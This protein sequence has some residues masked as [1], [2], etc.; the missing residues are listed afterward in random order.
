MK[1]NDPP[2]RYV[3]EGRL[4]LRKHRGG[5]G[6][7]LAVGADHISE[8]RG[9]PFIAKIVRRNGCQKAFDVDDMERRFGQGF[10][11]LIG[12]KMIVLG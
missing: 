4:S 11:V 9:T 1:L 6:C 10:D 5:K 8:G 12:Q 3:A 2:W 7:K